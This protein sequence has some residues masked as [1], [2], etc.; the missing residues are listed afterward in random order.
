VID[1][2]AL[3]GEAHAVAAWRLAKKHGLLKAVS[4][5][6]R[7]AIEEAAFAVAHGV[8][9]CLLAEAEKSAL[10]AAAL[11]VCYPLEE[12]ASG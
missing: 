7:R 10:V 6:E 8:A 2:D 11:D 12:A 1:A 9:E 4:P 5:R 3:R